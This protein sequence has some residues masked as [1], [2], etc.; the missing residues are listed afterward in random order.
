MG[1]RETLNQNPG[2]TTGATA[3][4]IILALG[5]I[6]WQSMG[7]GDN[8]GVPTKM[9]FSDDDGASF[10]A[11][12]IKK[13]P[14]FDHNGKQAVRARVYS[15]DKGKTKFVGFLERYTADAKGKI[16]KARAA[17]TSEIGIMEDISMTGMEVKKPKDPGWIKQSDSKAQT[18][19]SVAC[20]D[21]TRTNL[22]PLLP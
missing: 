4:I 13:V 5:F 1:I 6:I 2:L 18:V 7:G 14:P 10:F 15:C 21:G 9:Y 12:D 3:G 20:P 22:E 17:G 19:M 16:E 11:D 8:G